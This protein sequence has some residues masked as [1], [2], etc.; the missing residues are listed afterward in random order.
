MYINENE[1]K[2]KWKCL[3]VTN[4]N[5]LMKKYKNWNIWVLINFETDIPCWRT[6]ERRFWRLKS[7]R[8]VGFN[9]EK[10]S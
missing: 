9:Y 4:E 1:W 8:G 7:V 10:E 6:H 2:L 3:N 5:D